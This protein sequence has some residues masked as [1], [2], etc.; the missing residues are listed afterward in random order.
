MCFA[1][2]FWNRF[3]AVCIAE[4]VQNRCAK[5]TMKPV[6]WNRFCAVC[7]L[8][9]CFFVENFRGAEGGVMCNTILR[10]PSL[11]TPYHGFSPYQRAP[12]TAAAAAAAT[13]HVAMT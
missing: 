12:R 8:E 13:Q 2:V 10:Y 7:I 6:F 9:R 3:C 5:P 11:T 1:R 4:R